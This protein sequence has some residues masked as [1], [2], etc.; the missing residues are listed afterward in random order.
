MSDGKPAVFLDRDGTI[1]KLV[2]YIS[3][4]ADVALIDGAAEAIARLRG[5]GSAVIVVTNQAGIGKGRYT[6][7]DFWRVQRE[8]DRQ[9]AARGAT[10]DAVYFCPLVGTIE[11]MTVVEHEERKPGAGMLRRAA[12]EHG[13]D[14]A[15]SWMVGDALSDMHAGRNAGCRGT[16]LVRTGYGGKVADRPDA[17]D[18]VVDD[19]AAA[20]EVILRQTELEGQA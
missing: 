13:L 8:M 6:E 4:V 9:L 14:L 10:V 15:R 18:D 12:R 11:D 3:D 17:A 2:H 5:L 20:A 1:I 7:A 19:L 16:I